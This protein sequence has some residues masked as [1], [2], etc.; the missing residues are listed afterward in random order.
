ML[1]VVVIGYFYT[2]RPVFQKEVVSEDLARLQIEQRKLQQQMEKQAESLF[3]GEARNKALA[4]QRSAIE[5]QISTLSKKVVDSEKSARDATLRAQKATAEAKTAESTLSML[6]TQHY[7]LKLQGLLGELAAPSSLS[8]LLNRSWNSMSLDIFNVDAGD[9]VAEKLKSTDLQPLDLAKK[10]LLQLQAQASKQARAPGGSAD[11]LL[12]QN[13][14]KGIDSHAEELTCPT[15]SYSGWQSAFQSAIQ[16]Q[17]SMI[18]ECA[19][20]S[21]RERVKDE[22]WTPADI[23][24][25][26]ETESWK[27]QDNSYKASCVASYRYTVTRMFQE[28]WRKA[29][30][31]C[32]E[33]RMYVNDIV[34]GSPIDKSLNALTP[35]L[36]PTIEDI[37]RQF[38]NRNLDQPETKP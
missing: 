32:D 28:A 2:V 27:V 1:G 33:R 37:A 24:R 6:Q 3:A 7:G 36:A 19:S 9:K 20:A 29:D 31:P 34:M 21:W 23:R 5:A 26:Q 14:R 35:A 12:A 25:L 11:E 10:T 16:A 17:A 22:G 18:G 4:D 15:P 30:E 13:Y 8:E 38:H